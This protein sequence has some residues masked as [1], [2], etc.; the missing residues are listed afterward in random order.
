MHH[1]D[2][3]ILLKIISYITVTD[4]FPKLKNDINKIIN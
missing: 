4:D 1:R 2:K 3:I